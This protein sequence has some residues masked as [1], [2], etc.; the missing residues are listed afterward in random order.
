MAFAGFPPRA[1]EWFAGLEEDSKA[2][3]TATRDGRRGR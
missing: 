1:F 3:F 2:Y